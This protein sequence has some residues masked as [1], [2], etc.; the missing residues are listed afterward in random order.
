MSIWSGMKVAGRVGR[1]VGS[2]AIELCS[3]LGRSGT[4]LA[5]LFGAQGQRTVRLRVLILC[6][7]DGTPLTT[8]EQVMP[9]IARADEFLQR[10]ANIR[11]QPSGGTWVA[12]V[13]EHGDSVPERAL[14]QRGGRGALRDYLG[15]PGGFLDGMMR[16]Y[17]PEALFPRN[18]PTTPVTCFIVES[19]SGLRGNAIPVI[20]N[21]F[22]VIG[23]GLAP[24]P[25]GTGEILPPS[26]LA[27]ELG[28]CLGLFA[29]RS[30]KANLM[31]APD[32]R[33]AGLSRWQRMVARS[34][35]CVS[36]W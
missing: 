7:A 22:A 16:T 13:E 33:G 11:L 9:A 18:L 20:G 31:H 24:I 17:H 21:W 32:V 1:A 2:V 34:G 26:I 14:R 30:D 35:R 10:A 6:R 28:H 19:L 29:H 15:A 25:S 5:T 36:F 23:H 4:A 3:R 8:P 27:H 12:I